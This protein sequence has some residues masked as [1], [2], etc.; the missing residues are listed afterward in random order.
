MDQQPSPVPTL[1]QSFGCR[2]TG[3]GNAILEVA[4]QLRSV[5]RKHLPNV[6]LIDP[7]DELTWSVMLRGPQGSP[8][9]GGLFGMT[10]KFSSS[11]PESRPE[12]KFDT[13]I[14]H[15][16]ICERTGRW[17]LNHTAVCLSFVTSFPPYPNKCVTRNHVPASLCRVCWSVNDGNG[18]K[19]QAPVL[20]SAI[21]MLLELPNADSPLN[22]EAARLYTSNRDEFIRRAKADTEKNV[23][24]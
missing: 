1:K 17:L 19:Y 5:T 8:Y 13:N 2:F 9:A 22:H 15:P 23:F 12:V 20:I 7:Q 16:N 21:L 24:H 11:F 10:I 4:R 3:G 18:S 14:F 6:E